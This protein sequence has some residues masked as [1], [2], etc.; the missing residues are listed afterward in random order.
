M[1]YE[2][3]IGELDLTLQKY[4]LR[5]LNQSEPVIVD[6]DSLLLTLW[7]ADAYVEALY[8][9][10]ETKNTHYRNI[11]RLIEK[12]N[13]DASDVPWYVGLREK[14]AVST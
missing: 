8:L 13:P 3:T 9:S 12:H 6:P 4:K 1:D 2:W 10:A 5:S 14:R 11:G 7:D